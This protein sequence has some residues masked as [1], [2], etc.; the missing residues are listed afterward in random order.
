MLVMYVILNKLVTT[1]ISCNS[2]PTFH[3]KCVLYNPDNTSK[4]NYFNK[5][6]LVWGSP[7][8]HDH[9]CSIQFTKL[10]F[11]PISSL[12]LKSTV[13]GWFTARV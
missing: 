3:F 8:S 12:F 9:E 4:K 10:R 1:F 13:I 6:F 2:M 11:Y 5:Q 7:V